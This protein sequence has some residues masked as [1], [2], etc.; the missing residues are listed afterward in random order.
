MTQVLTINGVE[1]EFDDGGAPGT[2]AELLEHM[3]IKQATVVAEIDGTI[4]NRDDFGG[5]TVAPGQ[6]I[7]LI[8]FVGGG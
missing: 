5:T 2:L 4:I 7:E 6:A 8:R 1:R 3:N